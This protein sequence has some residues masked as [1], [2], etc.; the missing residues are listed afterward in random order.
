M[1]ARHKAGAIST[2]AKPVETP[3]AWRQKLMFAPTSLGRATS[4]A[5]D[6]HSSGPAA[7]ARIRTRVKHLLFA[8]F[9]AF[10]AGSYIPVARATSVPF[11]ILAQFFMPGPA[12]PG[13][14]TIRPGEDIGSLLPQGTTLARNPDFDH[15]VVLLVAGA[16]LGSFC[17]QTRIDQ[18]EL[19]A[20]EHLR[21]IVEEHSPQACPPGSLCP[22]EMVGAPP[23]LGSMHFL[24]AV[25]KPVGE[26]VVVTKSVVDPCCIK[27]R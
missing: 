3:F 27:M 2:W 8:T 16:Y 21:V 26:V 6:T 18:V 7:R 22:C 23:P 14:R 4:R 5:G 15:E 24:L 20:P 13:I 17:R 11:T 12:Q 19:A 10:A 25:P 9:L 1:S